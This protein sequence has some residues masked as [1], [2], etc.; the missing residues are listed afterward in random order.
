MTATEIALAAIL[1]ACVVI[2]VAVPAVA[3]YGW[4]RKR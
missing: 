3:V 2:V 4:M 1:T